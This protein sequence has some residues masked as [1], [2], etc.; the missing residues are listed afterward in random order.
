MKAVAFLLLVILAGCTAV[1]QETQQSVKCKWPE[2]PSDG[3]CCRDLNENSICDTIDYASEIE[4]QKQQ[5]Y[6]QAA[7]KAKETA[8]QSGKYKPTVVNLLY[9]N[10]SSIKS[11]RFYY[12]GDEVVVANGTIV[13]KL[14]SLYPL[15]DKT[16]N[17]RNMKVFVNTVWLDPLKRTA[18]SECIPPEKLIREGTGT[19]C[20]DFAGEKFEIPFDAFAFK[21]PIKWLEDLLYRTP[22][23]VLGGSHVGDRTTTL[24]KFTDLQDS[25]RKTHLWIDDQAQMPL[26]V[27]VW[28]VDTLAEQEDYLDFYII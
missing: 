26:R 23:T 11:Y 8:E 4:A 10:A 28:Q 24:Y 12:K 27:E 22:M 19:P 18:I 6:E 2:I 9:E 15:G 21:M 25:S 16:I 17:G 3:K 1:T 5:E 7:Q 13:R 14:T 20:D